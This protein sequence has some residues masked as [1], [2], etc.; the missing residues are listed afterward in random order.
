MK[1]L[2]MILGILLLAG[3]VAVPVMAWGPGMGWGH[4]MMGYRDNGPGYGNAY[5]NLTPDQQG[6][7]ESLDRKYYDETRALRDQIWTKSE[8]LNTVL[9]SANPDLTKAK[10]LQ[11]EINNL[12]ASLDEKTLNYEVEARKIAPDQRLGYA[13]G[14]WYG[15]HMGPYGHGSM[16][17][18]GYGQGYCWD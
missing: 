4:H 5:G 9:N 7:L 2:T 3:T 1:K 8:E 14:G 16:M 13:D 15:H 10:T 6:K 11:N 12:R 17:G 18:Y